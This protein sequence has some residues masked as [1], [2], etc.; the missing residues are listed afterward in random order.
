MYSL[1]V[2]SQK[3]GYALAYSARY[4]EQSHLWAVTITAAPN[5]PIPCRPTTLW[6][7]SR[8]DFQQ[9]RSIQDWTDYLD[10]TE[11][12]LISF[13]ARRYHIV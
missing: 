3:T 7:V 8:N 2:N 9:F 10:P 6:I 5:S 4:L 1:Y 13:L 11:P 12:R